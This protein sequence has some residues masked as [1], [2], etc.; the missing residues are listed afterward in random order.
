[1]SKTSAAVGLVLLTCCFIAPA[2][3]DV[4]F[5]VGERNPFLNDCYV[6]ALSEP[7]DIA[8]AR[9][10]IGYGPGTADQDIVIATVIRQPPGTC[11]LNRNYLTRGLPCWSWSAAFVSFAGGAIEIWDGNPTM[12][13]ESP[14]GWPTGSTMGFWAY[15]VVAELG[16]DFEPWMSNLS[17]NGSID[18]DDLSIL[19]EHWMEPAIGGP[20][21]DGSG[22]VDIFDL[23]VL[24]DHWLGCF[25]IPSAATYPNPADNG[26]NMGRHIVLRWAT[27]GHTTSHNVYFG[28]SEAEVSAAGTDDLNVFMGNVDTASWDIDDYNTHGLEYSTTYYWR[29]DEI[30]LCGIEKGQTWSFTTMDEPLSGPVGWWRFDEGS[31]SIASDSA[32]GNNGTLSGNTSWV[33]GKIGQYAIEFD[34]SDDYVIVPDD[35]SLDIVGQMTI[36]GWIKP[37][38]AGFNVILNKANAEGGFQPGNYQFYLVS[39]QLRLS[40][41]TTIGSDYMVYTSS[42][43]VSLGVWQ[44]IAVTIMQNGNVNF[45]IN[46]SAAGT[47]P[48]AGT[49]GVLNN[50]PVRMGIQSN[51]ICDYDGAMDDIRIYNRV[52]GA[53]EIYEIYL[54][55]FPLKANNCAPADGSTEVGRNVTL[56]WTAGR[57]AASHDIYFGTSFSEVNEADTGNPDVYMGSQSTT[58]WDTN[59]FNGSSLDYNTV[60]YWRIDE[61][62]A[63][64]EWRGDVWRFTTYGAPHQANNPSPSSGTVGANKHSV[65]SWTA[66]AYSDS[67]DVYFGTDINEVNIADIYDANVFMGNQIE[68]VW[69]TNNYD[70]CGLEYEK[71][72]YWRIDERNNFTVTRG[73]LW[74]FTTCSD[75]NISL[76]IVSLWQLNETEG[77]IAHDSA[78][79]SNGTI[80][81]GATWTT[82]KIGGALSFDGTNDYIDCGSGPSNY[83]N[84]TVSAWITTSADGVLISNRYNSASY[85]TWY[86]LSS[87]NIEIGDNSQGGYKYLTFHTTTLNGIWHHIVYTKNGTDHSIYVDGSLDQSFTS[88]ADI[89]QAGSLF[90]GRRW[91]RSSSNLWFNG[92]IDD[93]RIYNRALSD[94]EIR[95]LY[96][97]GL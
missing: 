55:A 80:Y 11:S 78:G 74:H 92:T 87:T 56:S 66:G 34:G 46:G 16:T 24:A 27:G 15:T 12:V 26:I 7:A 47:V 23:A 69:D 42:S 77:T 79:S 90:I 54:E 89:G 86:T 63:P 60:Y 81:G 93:V 48:Q 4:Y 43:S 10:L 17:V 91:N 49:F 45:Y 35:S 31:G 29:V 39:G 76:G 13:E 65:L 75:P 22:K 20:D 52:L 96:Q 9:D 59:N 38:A 67:H 25:R 3:G 57:H 6:I 37:D 44:H 40:H 72:Y 41:K 1:M 58:G 19:A 36:C 83:D 88:N 21:I 95:S 32:N 50:E 33:G 2:H 94:I 61:V 85:G 51:G 68:A 8:H 14:G 18:F 5:L 30:T 70:P 64:R 53:D 73:Q 82:G 71:T 84:I 28:T 97:S 62:N